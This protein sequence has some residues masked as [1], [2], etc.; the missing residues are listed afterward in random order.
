ML[1]PPLSVAKAARNLLDDFGTVPS[2]VPSLS[3][4]MASR[5]HLALTEN[6][7]AFEFFPPSADV[8]LKCVPTLLST[9]FCL[10]ERSRSQKRPRSWQMAPSRPKRKPADAS[11]RDASSSGR[12]CVTLLR[13]R[14]CD[15]FRDGELCGANCDCADCQNK[16]PE[17]K[18]RQAAHDK[19]MSS[20]PS[21]F[22]KKIKLNAHI[23]GCQCKKSRCQKRYCECY[24][25]GVPCTDKCRCRD[26]QNHT[27]GQPHVHSHDDG[28][29]EN[30]DSD[31]EVPVTPPRL[32]SKIMRGDSP[33]REMYQYARFCSSS[34]RASPSPS[35]S[36]SFG[37]RS[38]TPLHHN[39]FDSIL[40]SPMDPSRNFRV[41]VS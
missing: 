26:C 17:S 35:A 10:D 16:C 28:V 38:I 40:N 33:M 36:P 11:D 32:S 13:F 6:T 23:R 24:M 22:R 41:D 29:A 15:C 20:N 1:S 5:T 39:V 8:S 9:D 4:Q 30:S 7:V 14:Y 2:L 37:L 3:P 31:H 27:P 21:A 25:F 12:L 19:I 18:E 34:H